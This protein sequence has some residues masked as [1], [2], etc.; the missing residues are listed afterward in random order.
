VHMDLWCGIDCIFLVNALQ[1]LQPSVAA[2]NR[3]EMILEY[4][5]N[6]HATER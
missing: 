2:M 6:Q 4:L 3:F 1:Y 5:S